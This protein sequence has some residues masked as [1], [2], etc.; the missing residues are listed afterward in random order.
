[1]KPE[2]FENEMVERLSELGITPNE[3]KLY[4]TH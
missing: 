4:K 1:M 2:L 3:E